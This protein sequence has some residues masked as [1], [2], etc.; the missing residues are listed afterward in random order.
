MHKIQVLLLV[1]LWL[2]VPARGDVL[3][4]GEKPVSHQLVI[5]PSEHWAGRRIVAFPVRG[6]GGS[7]VVEPGVPFDFSSKYGTR[8]YSV[9]DSEPVPISVDAEWAASH[10]SADIPVSEVASVPLTSPLESI[11]TT[12]RIRELNGARFELAVVDEAKRH[13]PM[14]IAALCAAALLGGLGLL[15]L[16]RRRKRAAAAG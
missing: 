2:S 12:L 9:P 11:V 6:L 7:N 4:P 3:M 16:I 5:E 15:V 13:D 1:L 14:L 10:L 8:L